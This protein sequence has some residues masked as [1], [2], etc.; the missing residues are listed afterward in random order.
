QGLFFNN[1]ISDASGVPAV[2]KIYRQPGR[3]LVQT[4]RTT[5]PDVAINQSSKFQ[6]NEA[7]VLAQPGNYEAELTAAYDAATDP[8][9]SNNSISTFFTINP[10]LSGMYE[11]G[12][13]GKFLTIQDAV[14]ALYNC[15]VSGPVTFLLTDAEYTVGNINANIPAL[16][17]TSKIV[18]MRSVNT[19][20]WRPA[21]S[22]L[23]SRG[24]VTITLKSGAGV[25]I[26]FGQN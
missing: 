6:F 23:G 18:G 10:T 1:G 8:V 7:V 4:L 16:D 24:G 9:Q 26:K 3:V 20:T 21:D 17:L 15:G 19:V 5:V 25:G 12:G 11:V 2:L 14:D 22:R 13:S